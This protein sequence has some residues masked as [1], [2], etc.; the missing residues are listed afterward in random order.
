MCGLTECLTRNDVSMRSLMSLFETVTSF[1]EPLVGTSS[2]R[3]RRRRRPSSSRSKPRE[4]N[5][6]EMN[7]LFNYLCNNTCIEQCR[8]DANGTSKRRRASWR[9]T[10]GCKRK[11]EKGCDRVNIKT[12]TKGD[13]DRVKD[14]KYEFDMKEVR[15]AERRLKAEL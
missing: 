1:I 2:S 3:R 15:K 11:C 14:G 5:E 9:E 6:E 12:P 7:S 13:A 4:A 8:K 10:V